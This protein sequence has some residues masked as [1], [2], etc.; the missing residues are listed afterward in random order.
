[1]AERP[2]LSRFAANLFFI[3]LG[4]IPLLISFAWASGILYRLFSYTQAAGVVSSI[5]VTSSA[6]KHAT[7]YYAHRVKYLTQEGETTSDKISCMFYSPYTE[8]ESVTVYYDPQHP[9][10][11]L[12]NSFMTLWLIPAALF[13][14]GAFT[15]NARFHCL[16]KL[17]AA[18]SPRA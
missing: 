2:P 5:N 14:A 12:L 17:R 11:A 7:T 10:K 16:S 9:R 1:M 8:G 6:G 4:L 13:I 3:I 15:T 18:F